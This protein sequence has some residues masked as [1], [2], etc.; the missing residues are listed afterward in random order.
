MNNKNLTMTS[1]RHPD[2]KTEIAALLHRRLTPGRLRE[3][4]TNYHENDMAAALELLSREDRLTLYRLLDSTE[5][6][7]IFSYIDHPADYLSELSLR[8]KLEILAQLEPSQAADYLEELPKE[9]RD[10]LLDL[11]AEDTRS[12]IALL[13]SFAEEEL[14]SRMTTNFITIREGSTIREAMR[15]L[16]DQAAENDNIS[17]LYVVDQEERLVGAIDL[18]DLIIARDGDQLS[19]ITAASYP[20]VYATEAVEDCI[21]SLCDYSEDSI[22]VL[23]NANRLC[24]VLTAQAVGQ[25]IGEEL[26]EDY[27]KLG[28]LSSGEDLDEPL[29]RSI[30]KRLPWL[31]ILLGLGL[32]VSSV[33]G[34]F[35]AVVSQLTLIICFQSLVLDM[36]GNVGTQSLAVTIRVLTDSR[37]DARR[38]WS[39]VVKEA[40]VGLVNGAI[41]GLLSF[42]A[43]G[44]YLMLFKGQS[45]AVA[46][47]VSFCTGAALLLSMELSS[48]AGTT[49][50]LL[51]KKIHID[52][53][54]A[55]GPLITTINDL[56][57]V[58]SYYGLAWLFLLYLRPL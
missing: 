26:D 14:G 34:I 22:P 37:V 53:A 13:S 10:T 48:I 30:V 32:V 42:V 38:K 17:T 47:S 41:L 50:P 27:A 20:Y 6:A 45:A 54:V 35:E 21:D 4:L 40:R 46:F 16:V 8:R 25:L 5:L 19:D 33:V 52:P 15:A 58:M 49:I 24:G 43:I 31:I 2:Y 1:V 3:E 39:L 23:D 12:E 55:S 18:K 11:L 29:R 56:V 44:G 28:G 57:A 9:E 36:A 51:F 7:D